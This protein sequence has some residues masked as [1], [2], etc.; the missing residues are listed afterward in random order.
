MDLSTLRRRGA[1]LLAGLARSELRSALGDSEADFTRVFN[2][3]GDLASRDALACA[4]EGA[5]AGEPASRGA[6]AKLVELVAWAHEGR[7]TSRALDE[8]DCFSFKATV[9]V[10]GELVPIR[11]LPRR[12]A[13]ESR[14]SE[15]ERIARAFLGALGSLDAVLAR[16]VDDCQEIAQALDYGGYEALVSATSGIDLA[17]LAAQA[18]DVLAR[19]EDAWRDLAA[20]ALRRT[21]GRIAL[22]PRGEAAFHDLARNARL[23][24]LDDTFR[25]LR[26]IPALEK[27]F[28]AIGLRFDGGDRVELDFSERP[29]K[30]PEPIL[31]RID[32]PRQITV[33]LQPLGGAADYLAAFDLAG[34]AQHQ[35]LC[36][37]QAPMEDRWLGDESVP[38]G[39]GLAFAHFLLDPGFLRRVLDIDA[40]DGIE[41][42]RLIAIAQLGEFR[43]ACAQLI[44]ERTLYAEGPRSELKGLYREGLQKAM[45][46]DWPVERW[47]WDVEPR[48]ACAR[49]LRAFALEAALRRAMR[50]A[51]D[52]DHW[53]NPRLGSFLESYASRGQRLDAAALAKDLGG[54]LALKGAAARL[55]EVGAR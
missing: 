12:V 3:F 22:Q 52:E 36:S 10:A 34:R 7:K 29:G 33:A 24:L 51:C 30:R 16:R 1:A 35:A 11:E 43:K 18:A 27:A 5:A 15:R 28:E 19:T 53:R 41:A 48:F 55:I 8:R 14:R 23:A 17:A 13:Q 39:F 47:L 45:L 26:L 4:R 40:R 50:E 54:E 44:F 49:G 9:R 38:R 21:T 32:V 25:P 6:A 2:G 37:E 46:V 20:Y 42:A 31:A